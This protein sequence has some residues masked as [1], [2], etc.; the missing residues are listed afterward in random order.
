MSHGGHPYDIDYGRIGGNSDGMLRPIDEVVRRGVSLPDREIRCV[1]CHDRR[2]PWR[3]HIAL[4]PGSVPT[5]AVDRRR[6]QTY[7][8]ARALPAPRPGDDVGRKPLC[9]ACHALD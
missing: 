9:L 7:E 3:Y 8:N 6:P 1:T 2:S 4:P 5:H